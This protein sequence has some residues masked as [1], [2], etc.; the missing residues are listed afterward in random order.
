[1]N[2]E[3]KNAPALQEEEFIGMWADRD[4]MQDSNVYIRKLRATEWMK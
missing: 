4:D 1:M 3:I 2:N